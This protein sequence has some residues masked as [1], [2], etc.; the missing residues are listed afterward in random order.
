MDLTPENMRAM[1][2]AGGFVTAGMGPGGRGPDGGM[3]DRSGDGAGGVEPATTIFQSVQQLGLKLEAR[4]APV[5]TI[6][7][8]HAEKSPTGN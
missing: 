3:H 1:A 2:T 5:E 8:D 7:V 6:V 4:K